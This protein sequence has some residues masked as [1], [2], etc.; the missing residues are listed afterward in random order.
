MPELRPKMWVCSWSSFVPSFA[1]QS[2]R[3]GPRPKEKSVC[4]DVCRRHVHSFRHLWMYGNVPRTLVHVADGCGTCCKTINTLPWNSIGS[5]LMSLVQPPRPRCWLELNEFECSC[6]CYYLFFV[7][8][9]REQRS[10]ACNPKC[11]Q[12]GSSHLLSLCL[13]ALTRYRQIC[14]NC[15]HKILDCHSVICHWMW[16]LTVIIFEVI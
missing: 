11:D 2:L 9:H 15:I 16:T 8:E 13:E 3:L 7:R 4:C 12:P 5:T 1:V 14:Q 10:L 6:S